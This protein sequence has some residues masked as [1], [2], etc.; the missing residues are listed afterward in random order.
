MT[1]VSQMDRLRVLAKPMLELAIVITGVSVAF[2]LNNWN[3]SKKE[4]AER[5]KVLTSL[6]T[7]LQSVK[8]Y[9]PNFASYQQDR[10]KEWD[11]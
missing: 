4:H 8:K 1:M 3:E 9:F 6:R 11:V 2:V 10:I 7:E 5:V